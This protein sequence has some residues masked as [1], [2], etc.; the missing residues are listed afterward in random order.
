M[1]NLVIKSLNVRGLRDDRKRREMFHALHKSKYNFFL[2]QETHST[3][4]CETQWRTEWGGDVYYSHGTNVARGTCILIKK[5]VGKQVHNVIVDANGRYVILDIEIGNI[6]LTLATIYGPNSDDSDFFVDLAAL[7]ENIEN[8][9]RIIGGDFNVVF[10]IEK[11]KRGGQA[12]THANSLQVIQTWMEETDLIDI[13]RL[14]NPDDFKFTWKR[15]NPKPGIFCRLDYFLV[16]FGL[17]DKVIE[18]AITPGYKTDHSAITLSLDT[19]DNKRGP[20]FW[21]LNTSYLNDTDYTHLIKDTI[22]QTVR[23]N[24]GAN[25]KLLWDTMKCKIRGASIKFSSDKKKSKKNKIEIYEKKLQFFEQKLIVE[26][27]QENINRIEEI[28]NELEKHTIEITKGAMIRS[29]VRWCE[30]GEK[31]SKYFLNLEKRNHNNKT[32][33]KLQLENGN[34]IIDSEEIL[35]QQKLFYKKLYKTSYGE[36]TEEEIELFVQ[37]LEIPKVSNEEKEKQNQNIT[38]IELLASLKTLKNGRSPGIDGIPNEFYKV[39]WNDIKK[40]LIEAYTEAKEDCIL[41]FT[42]RQGQISLIPKKN[43]DPLLLKNWRPL[44]LL[45]SDYKILAKTIANRIKPSLENIIHHDQTGFLQNRYIGENIVKALDLIQIAEEEDI[46]AFLMFID[47]EKAYDHIEWPFL[48]KTLEL[49]GFD[50]NL[51]NWVKI[52]YSDITSCVTN[53]G[54]KS[55]FFQLTRGVRQGCPLSSYLFILCTEILSIS[56]RSNPDIHGIE[57]NGTEHKLSQFADDTWFSLMYD[58]DNLNRVLQTLDTFE[59]CSGL[60]INY[61]KTEL[62]RIGSLKNSNAKLYTQKQ[63]QWTNKVVKLLGVQLTADRNQLL[64]LNYEPIIAKLQ[65]IISVWQQRKITLFGK[66]TVIQSLLVSQLIYMFSVLPS[67]SR[68][69]SETIEKI[70][71]EYLWNNK[72][73]HLSKETIKY[74]KDQGGLGMIDIF[75]KDI[76]IKCAWVKRLQSQDNATWKKLV[77]FFVPEAN[78]LVWSGN[79]TAKDAEKVLKHN[80]SFWKNVL[81]SWATYNHHIPQNCQEILAEQIWFNSNVKVQ[82]STVFFKELSQYGIRYIQDLINENYTMDCNHIMRKFGLPEKLRMHVNMIIH[83]VPTEWKEIIKHNRI[84]L[85]AANRQSAF[86]VATSKIKIS[87]FIYSKLMEKSNEELLQKLVE[88]WALD[89]PNANFDGKE[90]ENFFQIIPKSIMSPKHR[91]FQFRLI[92]RVLVTNKNLRLWKIKE[93][94]QC[95]F[96]GLEC[97]TIKHILWDCMYANRIWEALF[98]WINNKTNTNIIFTTKDILLGITFDEM[99]VFNCIFIITKQYIYASKCLDQKPDFNQLLSKIK[100]QKNVEKY[101]AMK[102]NKLQF[103]ENKWSMLD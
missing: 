68:E 30:E 13:W 6:R 28:K 29:R 60:K 21:K 12:Q 56:I 47:F 87:K 10:N 100:Y 72:K 33:N 5:N 75:R 22:L 35:N 54:W 92:H 85:D 73:H 40:Y 70:L 14:K 65:N 102:N 43:R 36:N 34:V 77:E 9:N 66:I 46:E 7:T 97:E 81:T 78:E 20:G 26:N 31:H 42:Q 53:N 59:R 1:A 37:N 94:D 74:S 62:L 69:F 96:C 49:F 4:E 15:I 2:L 58:Q 38:E 83:A 99:V 82:K 17:V 16:S 67:P 76:S 52:L 101:T 44:S 27:T 63:L 90:F 19:N 71:I 84:N 93:S 50:Q 55:D 11:D 88:K 8:D 45:N 64:K 51:I 57:H 3:K 61:E 41:S 86:E 25:A 95:T 98:N 24:E 91:D 23:D 79:L 48:Y 80:S 39:F 89:I 103:Y 18:S 32:I